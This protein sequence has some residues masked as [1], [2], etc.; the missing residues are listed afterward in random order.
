MLVFQVTPWETYSKIK[1]QRELEDFHISL[2]YIALE[3][4]YIKDATIEF[5]KVLKL[6]PTNFIAINGIYLSNLFSQLQSY[7]HNISLSLQIESQ[8]RSLEIIEKNNLVHII[9]KYFGDLY[10]RINELEKANQHYLRALELNP[11]YTDA[12]NTYGWFCYTVLKNPNKM[13]QYFDNMVSND[14]FDFRGLHG[15]SYARYMKTLASDDKHFIE[16]VLTE[17]IDLCKRASHLA[18]SS[19]PVIMDFGEISRP[20][21]PQLAMVYHNYALTLLEEDMLIKVDDNNRDFLVKLLKKDPGK[22]IILKNISEKKSWV[23]YQIAL[24][25]LS[26]YG[27]DSSKNEFYL[28]MHNQHY[29]IA[30]DLDINNTVIDIYHDQKLALYFLQR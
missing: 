3:K 22:I 18:V 13:Q 7:D 21:S 19:L 1:Q 23:H 10:Y 6:N 30:R 12:L 20:L 28:N 11:N 16:K 2:S 8:L 17:A 15:A 25:A 24:D 5:E 29:N 27:R 4:G 9:E 26:I 14:P